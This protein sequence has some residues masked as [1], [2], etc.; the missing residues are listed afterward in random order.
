MFARAVS[1]RWPGQI[2]RPTAI[3]G[4]RVCLICWREIPDF[5]FGDSVNA[6]CVSGSDFS[7]PISA[8]GGLSLDVEKLK[9]MK[10]DPITPVRHRPILFLF[11]RSDVRI[12]EAA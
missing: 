1:S 4:I 9:E 3:G 5:V 6:F 12:H 10:L 11:V 2:L 8:P 7:D